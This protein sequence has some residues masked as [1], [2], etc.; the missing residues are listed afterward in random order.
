MSDQDMRKGYRAMVSGGLS[1][2]GDDEIANLVKLGSE[3]LAQRG[4]KELSPSA[5]YLQK[6]VGLCEEFI[7]S[8][9]SL[10]EVGDS[11]AK[12]NAEYDGRIPK[13]IMQ[14]DVPN[15]GVYMCDREDYTDEEWEEMDEYDRDG[16]MPSFC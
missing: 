3:T 7:H 9:S 13:H 8:Q 6:Y 5:E 4:S 12:L 2:M 11:I 1:A 16:W 15:P 10:R 14:H